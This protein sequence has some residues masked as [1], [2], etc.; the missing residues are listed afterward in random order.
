MFVTPYSAFSQ[1][2]LT[3]SHPIYQIFEETVN[4]LQIHVIVSRIY[5]KQYLL[6][7]VNENQGSFTR[8]WL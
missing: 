5:L 6:S 7:P 3:L 8:V 2:R 1:I 4:S